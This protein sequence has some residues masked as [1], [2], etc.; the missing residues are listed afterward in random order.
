[1]EN[2]TA[3][4]SCFARAYDIDE[5]IYTVTVAKDGAVTI[6]YTDESGE[7]KTL[8]NAGEGHI[9]TIGGDPDDE[10]A[11]VPAERSFYA[12]YGRFNIPNDRALEGELTVV[13][14]WKDENGDEI[15]DTDGF[16]IPVVHVDAEVPVRGV[17]AP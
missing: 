7:G 11:Y 3:K 1:M 16:P 6:A 12:R 5:T 4:V 8:T 2:I 10:E 15:T 13:K 9:I 17:C 14:V